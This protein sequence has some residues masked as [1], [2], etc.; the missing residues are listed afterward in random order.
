[1]SAR[2]IDGKAVAAKLRV[3]YK[4][5]IARLQSE[6][7][8]TPGLAVILVGEDPA[9]QVYV[10]NKIRDCAEVGIRSSLIELPAAT[11]EAELLGRIDALNADALVHG[12]LIQLPLPQHIEIRKVLERDSVKQALAIGHPG[13]K[14]VQ[15]P[16][17]AKAS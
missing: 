15:P 6:H 5:R 13:A 8:V 11:P 7:R 16:P 14:Y 12:I 9:S 4:A 17:Q 1:L 10:R 3:E 2:V